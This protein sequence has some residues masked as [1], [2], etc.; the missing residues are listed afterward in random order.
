MKRDAIAGMG[1]A[2]WMQTGL[3][4]DQPQTVGKWRVIKAPEGDYNWG[5]SFLSM[6]ES[7]KNKN[8]AWEFLKYATC[9]AEGQNTIFKKS[10]IF[11]AYKPAWKDPVY[12][13]P[14]E[15]FGGQ[16][17]FRLWLDISEGVPGNVVS[18][19]DRQAGDILGAEV[20]K[21]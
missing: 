7:G 14:V 9:T 17:A 5:G 20:T 11:P 13:Q 12:D 16:K 3:T 21:I 4:R 15:F 1:I 6:P 18:P 19:N 8:A 2:C 10:G